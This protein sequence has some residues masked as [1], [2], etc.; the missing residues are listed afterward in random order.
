MQTNKNET[1]HWLA[2]LQ[3]AAT[4][5]QQVCKMLASNSNLTQVNSV[6]H[7]L[8]MHIK[9]KATCLERALLRSEKPFIVTPPLNKRESSGLACCMGQCIHNI[10]KQ[11]FHHYHTHDQPDLHSGDPWFKS[12]MGHLQANSGIVSTSF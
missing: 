1:L 8:C 9:N 10:L 6:V 11:R 5:S 2:E 7:Y 12:R 4:Y 3:V